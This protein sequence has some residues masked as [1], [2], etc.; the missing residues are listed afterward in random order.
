MEIKY[1]GSISGWD[2]QGSVEVISL[3]VSAQPHSMGRN[4]AGRGKKVG[5]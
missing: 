4:L 2:D 5:A 1:T 3:H